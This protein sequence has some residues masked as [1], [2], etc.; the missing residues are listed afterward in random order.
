MREILQLLEMLFLWEIV[1]SSETLRLREVLY[2]PGMLRF[3]RLF[4]V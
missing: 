3:A 4:R 2:L 1:H